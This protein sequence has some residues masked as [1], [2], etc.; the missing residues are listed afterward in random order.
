M[1]NVTMKDI[2][3]MCNVSLK[4]VSRVVNGSPN[5]KLATRELVEKTMQE[6]GYRANIMA[7]GLKMKATKTIIVFID[8]HRDRYWGM[9]HTKMITSLFRQASKNGYKIV[10]SPSSASDHIEDDTDGFHLLSSKMADGAIILDNQEHDGRLEYLNRMKIPYVLMGQVEDERV[11]WVDIDNEN[12]GRVGCEYLVDRGYKHVC[13]LLGQSQYKVNQLRAKGFED[14]AKDKGID[15][16]IFFE[17]D[18]MKAVNQKVK[19]IHKDNKIDAF[20]ISGSERAIGAYSAANELGLRI[21]EDMAVLGIDN[22][23]I[24]ENV[25]PAMSVVDQHCNVFAK[26]VFKLL[27][28]LLTKDGDD[29]VVNHLYVQNTIVERAST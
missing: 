19:E 16:K 21:P 7:R 17:M 27:I 8:R 1:S 20:F 3:R 23:D 15:Y 24:C 26:N 6:Y 28:E 29:Q 14:V 13:F 2:A 4:T 10:V 22:L 9:W 25:Y 11:N 18:S 12:L 5:V